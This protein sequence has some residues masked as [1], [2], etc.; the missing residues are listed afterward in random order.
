MESA[1]PQR[2]Q[3]FLR[4]MSNDVKAYNK[5]LSLLKQ[6]KSLYTERDGKANE[7]NI[8]LQAPLLQQLRRTSKE[9]MECLISLGLPANEDGVAQLMRE[10]PEKI[11]AQ[12]NL[13]W[14]S[15]H[16]LILECQEYS[17]NNGHESATFHELA[18]QMTQTDTSQ[19]ASPL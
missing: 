12:A 8:R 19:Q 4:S 1:A 6:Q 13:Q 10:L 16:Q 14:T 3:Y 9:R 11:A 18:R 5:L 17:A 7:A 2:I 15:L